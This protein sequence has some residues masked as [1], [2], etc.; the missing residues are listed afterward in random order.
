MVG[1]CG[2]LKFINSPSRRAIAAG[3]FQLTDGLKGKLNREVERYV[4]RCRERGGKRDT[5]S[6]R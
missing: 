3:S 4:N 2:R 6:N 1:R 5:S